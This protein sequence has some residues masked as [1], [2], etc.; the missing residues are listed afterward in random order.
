MAR[1]AKF[2]LGFL[3]LAAETKAHLSYDFNHSGLSSIRSGSL[4]SYLSI[5][6]DLNDNIRCRFLTFR[7]A[8]F[9]TATPSRPTNDFLGDTAAS[10]ANTPVK[11]L[12]GDDSL[13]HRG[14]C[15][16]RVNGLVLFD[17]YFNVHVDWYATG[18][19]SAK[20]INDDANAVT[21]YGHL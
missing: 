14:G 13:S 1:S 6:V 12:F 5:F 7:N 11:K 2:N 8:A 19:I 3:H 20:R 9:Q 17:V 16:V 15:D 21:D 4:G 18:N 10:G